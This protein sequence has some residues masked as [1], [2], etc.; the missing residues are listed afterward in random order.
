M[1]ILSLK[2]LMVAMVTI[3]LTTNTAYAGDDKDPNLSDKKAAHSGTA[4]T[5][6]N[7]LLARQMAAYSKT[8]QDALGLVVAARM[9][10]DQ[11]IQMIQ[12]EKEGGSTN[13]AQSDP[14]SVEALLSLAREH[15]GGRAEIVALIDETAKRSSSGSTRTDRVKIGATRGLANV[16]TTEPTRHVGRVKVNTVDVYKNLKYEGGEEAIIGVV[17][18]GESDIDCYLYDEGDHLIT[19]DTDRS[20]ICALKWTPKWTG[21]FTLRI[22][23]MGSQASTYVLVT[24]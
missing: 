23:N 17:G 20:H 2:S 1:N 11:T 16:N 15:S 8:H 19:S 3:G 18:D 14:L 5:V 24:N 13:E 6:E 22:K 21:K 10:Q 4:Q 7:L 12:R 9:L